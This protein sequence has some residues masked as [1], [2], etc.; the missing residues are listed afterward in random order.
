MKIVGA[1]LLA[2]TASAA[3]AVAATARAPVALP[4][5]A[6]CDTCTVAR[7]RPPAVPVVEATMVTG[8][9]LLEAGLAALGLGIVAAARSRRRPA[10]VTEPASAPG[11]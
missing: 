5:K 9:L 6:C 4:S 2:C 3:V 10:A 8:A 7:Y 11:A 1:V